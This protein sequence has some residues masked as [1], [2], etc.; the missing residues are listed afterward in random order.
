MHTHTHTSI[1]TIYIQFV[2]KILKLKCTNEQTKE[3]TND[4]WMFVDEKIK[5]N[6]KRREWKKKTH[7]ENTQIGVHIFKM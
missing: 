1:R 2:E 6:G 5:G 3:R 4:M 7:E